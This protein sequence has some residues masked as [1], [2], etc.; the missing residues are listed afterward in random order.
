MGRVIVQMWMTADGVVQTPGDPQEDTRGGFQHGGWSLP[1]F[2]E[3]AQAW[4]LDNLNGV[5]GFLLGRRTYEA[6]ASHWP[7]ASEEEQPL[8]QPLNKGR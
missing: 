2:D 1:Y 6:F 7:N 5:D 4:V 3:T 8:A